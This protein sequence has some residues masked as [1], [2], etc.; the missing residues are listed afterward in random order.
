MAARVGCGFP[1]NRWVSNIPWALALVLHVHSGV[2]QVQL[3]ICRAH[4]D[5]GLVRFC[6]IYW[7]PDRPGQQGHASGGLR[8]GSEAR[9]PG[10]CV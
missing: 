10:T 4:Q 6:Y 1:D 5:K 7:S 9:R 3:Y 2:W 8:P